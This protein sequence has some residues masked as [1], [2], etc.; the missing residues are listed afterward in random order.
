MSC[1]WSARL[2]SDRPSFDPF[3]LASSLRSTN[4]SGVPPASLAAGVAH[5]VG[6]DSM[7]F[8]VSIRF[9]R[10]PSMWSTWPPRVPHDAFGVGYGAGTIVCTT[11]LRFE[12]PGGPPLDRFGARARISAIWSG[13]LGHAWSCDCGVGYGAGKVTVSLAA[14]SSVVPALPPIM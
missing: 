8:T 9:D 11:S 7:S 14:S 1:A 13:V 2:V 10:R 6:P 12:I 5:G 4:L 3:S